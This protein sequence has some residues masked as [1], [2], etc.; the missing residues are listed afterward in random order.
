MFEKVLNCEQRF[1]LIL[2]RSVTAKRKTLLRLSRALIMPRAFVV[3]FRKEHYVI[4][5][6]PVDYVYTYRLHICMINFKI[7]LSHFN[8]KR[9]DQIELSLRDKLIA[10]ESSK[11]KELQTKHWRWRT[12]L[13]N[14]WVS[15]SKWHFFLRFC[16][17]E[18]SQEHF[19]ELQKINKVC[20]HNCNLHATFNFIQ[21]YLYI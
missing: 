19:F 12:S 15:F 5:I 3:Y 18:V 17:F 7:S 10:N 2:H 13:C 11:N 8:R 21:G 14:S 6:L 16:F 9:F 4:W 1:I 20:V